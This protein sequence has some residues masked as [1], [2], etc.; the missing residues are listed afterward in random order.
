MHERNAHNFPLDLASGEPQAIALTALAITSESWLS[1][2]LD[3]APPKCGCFSI[4]EIQKTV[5]LPRRA[6]R[7]SACRSTRSLMRSHANSQSS[8]I[9]GSAIS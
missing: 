9:I 2:P 8:K 4:E 7:V 3:F 6:F 1:Q 5:V